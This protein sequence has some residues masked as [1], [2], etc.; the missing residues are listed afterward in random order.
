MSHRMSLYVALSVLASASSGAVLAQTPFES[1]AH[2]FSSDSPGVIYQRYFAAGAGAV[3]PSATNN[4]GGGAN[5]EAADGINYCKLVTRITSYAYYRGYAEN[6][7]N[8]GITPPD[9]QEYQSLFDM[10]TGA[11]TVNHI[12]YFGWTAKIVNPSDTAKASAKDCSGVH[13]V[14]CLG[15]ANFAN[16]VDRSGVPN[17][18][19]GPAGMDKVGGLSPLPVPRVNNYNY[20]S[21]AMTLG[22][23][24]AI[25]NTGGKTAAGYDLYSALIVRTGPG[26]CPLPTEAELQFFRSVSTNSAA[27]NRSDLGSTLGDQKCATFALKIN[28]GS[29][30]NGPVFSRYLSANGQAIYLDGYGDA[31]SVY[32]ITARW[33]SAN[34]IDVSW[35]TSLEDG[36]RGFYVTRAT[37]ANGPY[38]RVSSLI[39]AHREPSLYTFVDAVQMQ[40]VQK[41]TGLYYT[42]ETV[43]ID[44]QV[45]SFGPAKAQLPLPG[46]SVIQ[47]RSNN[48]RE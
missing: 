42:I 34:N 1:G 36:L 30:T 47:G 45:A 16:A 33:S 40:G 2:D 32:D 35:K 7:S 17:R 39:A 23:D 25:S 38:V 9:G 14:S 18:D 31:A 10:Q 20:T 37:R 41:A 13:S 19:G 3:N 5:V 24:R 44:D 11:G 27:F 21:G 4:C 22:W 29:N 43:D 28:Y 46:T 8:F 26:D 48:R 15:N 6:T 12:G